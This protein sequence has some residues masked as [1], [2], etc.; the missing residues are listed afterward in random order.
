MK[1]LTHHRGGSLD[2][3]RS[4]HCINRARETGSLAFED[5]T[6]LSICIPL[7]RAAR[8]GLSFIPIKSLIAS[9]VL[10]RLA[11]WRGGARE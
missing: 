8:S 2:R 9:E 10:E 1:R 7:S 5:W 11:T 6:S 4:V 3:F